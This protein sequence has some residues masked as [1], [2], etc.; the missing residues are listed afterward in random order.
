M[1]HGIGHEKKDINY[2]ISYLEENCGTLYDEK[3]TNILLGLIK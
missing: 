2:T 3:V 1:L